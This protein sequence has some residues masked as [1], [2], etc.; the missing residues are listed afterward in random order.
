MSTINL[1]EMDTVVV[2][3][4]VLKWVLLANA[5]IMISLACTLQ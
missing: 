2:E 3:L 4:N 1:L 5:I